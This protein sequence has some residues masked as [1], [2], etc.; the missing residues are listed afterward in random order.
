[1]IPCL[2][3]LAALGCEGSNEIVA[4]QAP[5]PVLTAPTPTPPLF[6]RGK[7]VNHANRPLRARVRVRRGDVEVA[8]TYSSASDGIFQLGPLEGGDY[9][10]RAF[11]S[12]CSSPPVTATVPNAVFW[13]LKIPGC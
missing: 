11:W 12:L 7:V 3:L 5:T 8:A 1:M 2:F 13:T 9:E 10:L 6:V 4:P